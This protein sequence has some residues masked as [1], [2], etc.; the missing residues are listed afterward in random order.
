MPM[1]EQTVE[2]CRSAIRAILEEH[3]KA[4]LFNMREADFRSVLLHKLRERIKGKVSVELRRGKDRGVL[5][6]DKAFHMKVWTSRVHS[7]VRLLPEKEKGRLTY[8]IVVLKDRPV[9]FRVRQSGTDVLE[10]LQ[11]EDVEVVI[12]MK[13][14]PSNRL[15]K[16]FEEDIRKL[17]NRNVGNA[18]AKRIFVAIDKSM[19]LGM[20]FIGK[21]KPNETWRKGLRKTQRGANDVEVWF[22]DEHEKPAS[23]FAIQ[24]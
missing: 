17:R 14:A 22:L 12:E 11:R 13:A 3:A 9:V 5:P 20:P 19:P 21:R 6:I 7:E 10:Q 1:K 24:S 15:H 23:M 16:K 8:D 2:C 18:K 4:P